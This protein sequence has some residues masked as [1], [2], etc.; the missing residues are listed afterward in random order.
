[1]IF[2]NVPKAK[3]QLVEKGLVYT[4]RSSFRAVGRTRAVEGSYSKH[5]TLCMVDVS[6]TKTVG[7]PSDLYP[8]LHYSGFKDV[9]IWWS[10][11]TPTART[12]YKVERVDQATVD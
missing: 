5:T 7:Y 11:A 6:R 10:K 1:M 9:N 4:L 3:K 12:L 2:F 8:Y